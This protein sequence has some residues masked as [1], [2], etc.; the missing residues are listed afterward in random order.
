V[1]AGPEGAGARA[2]AKSGE[3][4]RK[5]ELMASVRECVGIY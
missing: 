5:L 2:A 1:L 3:E 4:S